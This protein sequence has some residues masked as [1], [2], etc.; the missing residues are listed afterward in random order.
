MLVEIGMVVGGLFLG[1]VILGFLNRLNKARQRNN[2]LNGDYG[3]ETQ[4]AT[5]L[6]DEGDEYFTLAVQNLPQTEMMELGIIAES[7]EE[8][9]T[10]TIERFEELADDELPEEFA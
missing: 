9:R 10:K 1:L 3:D 8:L 7:K 4:W 5:E 6:I 2:A